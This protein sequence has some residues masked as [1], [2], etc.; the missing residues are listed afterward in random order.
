MPFL[1]RGL[2]LL[3][4]TLAA[5]AAMAAPVTV[6]FDDIDASGG[7]VLLTSPYRGLNWSNFLAYTTTP[8]FDGFNN[9]IVSPANAAYSGGQNGGPITPIVG[10]ISSGTLFDF[11]SADLG[12]GYYN[13]LALTVT[14]QRSGSTLFSRTV[15]LNTAGAQAFSFNFAAIDTLLFTAAATAGTTD[16]FACG[17]FNCTQF[18][19]DDFTFQPTDIVPPPP[20][21]PT[22]IPEPNSLALVLTAFV[23]GTRLRR[24]RDTP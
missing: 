13:G 15:T 4:A 6:G 5:S 24:P 21:P 17:S 11:L 10:S 18:T 20:P 22:S 23:L 9:G 1:T 19:L 3:T 12:A 14:G 7:D 2:A 16:P 8:G